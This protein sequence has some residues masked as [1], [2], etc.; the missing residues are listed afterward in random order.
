MAT[1]IF[2]DTNILLSFYDYTDEDIDQLR[3]VFLLSS[4]GEIRFLLPQQVID[5][6]Y[7]N[8][9]SRLAESMKRLSQEGAGV[10]QMARQLPQ[11]EQFRDA[12]KNAVEARKQLAAELLS[13]AKE[14][15]LPADELIAQ[16]FEKSAVIKIT[17]EILS[18]ATRRVQIGNPPGKRG[19]LGDAINW[20]CVLAELDDLEDLAFI[21]QDPDYQSRLDRDRFDDFLVREYESIAFG[22]IKFYR[23]L[24]KF[25]SERY[26]KV[27]LVA[28]DATAKA[29]N[30]LGSS[31]SFADT[32]SIIS[33]LSQA[34]HFTS[35][36]V[37]K[38]IEAAEEN[39]QV[40]WIISDA[41]VASF[42]QRLRDK[43]SSSL[44]PDFK[45]RL[46]ALSQEDQAVVLSGEESNDTPD[47]D[48]EELPF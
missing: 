48:Y 14:R 31:P 32:H 13:R 21:S 39:S 24:K 47:F 44:S 2:I 34:K 42:Y 7:R 11:Y 29:V 19:S 35:R 15:R 1:N 17:E 6:F 30:D 5:E 22:V 45:T 41:D 33:Q 20:E 18:R 12:N 36:Q 26:P 4:E 3:S 23:T 27:E 25:M 37:E 9:E 40:S 16:I 28:F 38:L 10:P 43:H 46:H 8:R